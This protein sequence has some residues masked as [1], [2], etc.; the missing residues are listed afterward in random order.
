MRI[1]KA[2]KAAR[3][4]AENNISKAKEDEENLRHWVDELEKLSPKDGEEEELSR[5]RQEMMN[6]EKILAGLN[7]AYGA[8]TEGADVQRAIRSAQAAMD[9]ADAFGRGQI[10]NN[11]RNAGSG[12]D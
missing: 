12:F 10:S 6:A 1:I 7:Y 3:I 5:R 2:A 4:N 9:K 8:L 11:Y